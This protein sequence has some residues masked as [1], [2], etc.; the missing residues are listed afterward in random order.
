MQGFQQRATSEFYPT[1]PAL[2]AEMV[3]PFRTKLGEW[4]ILDPQAGDGAILDYILNTRRVSQRNLYA[5][6]IDEELKFTLQ[7]KDY[8]VI[9]N[10]FLTYSGDYLFDLIVMN[11]PFSNGDAHLL[12][13]WDVLRSGH[14]VCLLNAETI[15]NPCTSRR[16]LLR[17]I[18][19]HHGSVEYMGKAFT[20]ARRQTDCEIVMVRL[21]KQEPDARFTFDFDT[22]A[23]SHVELNEE[24]AG[25]QVM[26]NDLTGAMLRQYELSKRAYADYIKAKKALKFY[27]QGLL[28]KYAYVDKMADECYSD[29][30]PQAYNSFLNQFKSSA[31]SN[32]ISKLGMS[33]FLTNG[34]MK[35]FEKFK[36]SQGAMDL[37]RE[38]IFGLIEMLVMNRHD[39]MSRAVEDVFDNF[40]KYHK[41]NRLHIEGWKT[42]V[43]WKVGKKVILPRYL[44]MRYSGHYGIN[45]HYSQ[46]FAD[47]DKVMSFLSGK[48]LDL[49]NTLEQTIGTIKIGDSDEHESEFFH[50]RC[51]KKG[52]MHLRFKCMKLWERFNYEAC[53]NKNWLPED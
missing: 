26:M 31:W 8:K 47:I 1:D 20:K 21:E 19:E 51:Y 28:S 45:Y 34:V 44:E 10:D 22:T 42:N 6:E 9:H 49:I 5:I 4:Q 48:N 50:V 35:G 52:T 53:K 3:A 12:K 2:I 30:L 29:N 43:A 41:Q 39:I 38:N 14:I 25:N 16:R 24:T 37:T 11:P 18:I 27:S 23:E 13:A 36:K 7:G 32:I 40:T 46:E 17:S 15:D 33:K